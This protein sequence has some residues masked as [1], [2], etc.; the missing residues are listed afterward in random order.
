MDDRQEQLANVQYVKPFEWY[1][2]YCH[3]VGDHNNILHKLPS[4]EGKWRTAH[5]PLN[6]F[7]F[8][9]LMAEV[10]IYLVL[11]H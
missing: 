2:K 5:W 6:L 8:L 3:I 9:L 1:L 10:N 11:K 4:L 7:T